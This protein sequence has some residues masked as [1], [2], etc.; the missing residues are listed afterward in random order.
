[1]FDD[2]LLARC[3]YDIK[4]SLI[5][6]TNQAID[7]KGGSHE[8]RRCISRLSGEHGQASA[9]AQSKKRISL[10]L[11]SVFFPFII[12]LYLLASHIAVD[13]SYFIAFATIYTL[14]YLGYSIWACSTHCPSCGH[15]M[16]K[17]YFF[18]MPSLTCSHCGHNLKNP[19]K[20]HG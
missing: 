2:Q 15:T 8:K 14:Y 3:S 9:H 20:F 13:R 7:I 5:T 1:M 17:K 6:K 19:L 12:V 10:T 4:S 16:S 18:I 11:L